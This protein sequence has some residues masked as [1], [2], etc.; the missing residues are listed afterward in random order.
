MQLSFTQLPFQLWIVLIVCVVGWFWLKRRTAGTS[1]SARSNSRSLYASSDV[2][3]HYRYPEQ[4]RSGGLEL[5]FLILALIVVLYFAWP[6][7]SKSVHI[8]SLQGV[9]QQLTEKSNTASGRVVG[10]P[11]VTADFIDTVLA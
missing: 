11:T 10:S 2:Y 4:K 7:I 6:M 9:T 8:P 1:P 3:G 5:V